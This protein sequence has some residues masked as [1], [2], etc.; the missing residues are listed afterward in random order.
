M[1]HHPD[2]GRHP[3]TWRSSASTCAKEA[4]SL[5]VQ[6]ENPYLS[7]SHSEPG[8]HTRPTPGAAAEGAPPCVDYP[9]S[10]HLSLPERPTTANATD[11]TPPQ[12]PADRSVTRM[13]PPRDQHNTNTPSEQQQS[14]EPVRKRHTVTTQPPTATHVSDHHPSHPPTPSTL[15]AGKRGRAAECIRLESGSRATDR[16]FESL[17]FRC[18]ARMSLV[19]QE[20]CCR[21]AGEYGFSVVSRVCSL[22]RPSRI[23]V[24]T[25]FTEV[26]R[27]CATSA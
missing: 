8:R 19:I 3:E 17:R 12:P 18:S 7:H 26:L 9:A 22:S 16:G 2:A 27:D 5:P 15:T 10:H 14:T 25:V 20:V 23:R 4:S 24:F 13:R 1:D 11:V 6:R 21:A